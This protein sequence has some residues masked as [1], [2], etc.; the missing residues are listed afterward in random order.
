LATGGPP[1]L[2]GGGLTLWAGIAHDR[3]RIVG[4][5]AGHR[6]QVT[7]IAIHHPEEG[8]DRRLVSGD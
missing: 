8:D 4:K 1:K 2:G 6:L 5:Y 3:C 7:D